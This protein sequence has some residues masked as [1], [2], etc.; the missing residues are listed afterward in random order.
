MDKCIQ[1][2]GYLRV[3]YATSVSFLVLISEISTPRS[4]STFS[5]HCS[6]MGYKAG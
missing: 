6:C 1:L 2:W 3:G 4:Y 5:P